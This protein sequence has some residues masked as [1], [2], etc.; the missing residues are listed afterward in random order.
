MS[1]ESRESKFLK[2]AAV[3][4]VNLLKLQHESDTK[5]NS[6]IPKPPPKHL[7]SSPSLLN[8]GDVRN[9]E[10]PT[11]AK[12][13]EIDYKLNGARARSNTGKNVSPFLRFFFQSILN[14]SHA[15]FFFF[16]L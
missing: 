14:T 11:L 3:E 13:A 15:Y 5:E 4:R 6:P 12:L 1:S 2:E 7:P 8:A 10:T 16:F 9:N